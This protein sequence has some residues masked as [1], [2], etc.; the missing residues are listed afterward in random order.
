MNKGRSPLWGDGNKEMEMDRY[1]F[2]TG[3]LYTYETIDGLKHLK[4]AGFRNIELMPQC[5]AD[6]SLERLDAIDKLGMHVSSIHFPLAYFALLYNANPE[7]RKEFKEY[8]GNLSVFLKKAGTHIM[9]IHTET[10]YK[11]EMWEKVGKPIRDNIRYLYEKMGESGVTLCMENHPEGVGQYP[12]TLDRYV[13]SLDMPDMKIIIDTTESLEGDV[14]PYFFIKNLADV[15][16]HLHLSDFADN[17]KH[18]P[19]GEGSIDWKA[20]FAL[21]RERGYSGYYTL[22]PRYKYYIENIDE[23]LR[24]DYEY[25]SSLV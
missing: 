7:M 12:D 22:E 15:P 17:T 9:V 4:R 24:K 20:L 19:I 18:L 14:D 25:L 10:P 13:E 11:G 5:M 21:L 8:V 3:A 6:T 2:S 16:A 23:R 1:A